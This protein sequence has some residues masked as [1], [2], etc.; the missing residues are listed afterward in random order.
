MK[1]QIKLKTLK[2]IY[3]AYSYELF[4][5]NNSETIVKMFTWFIDIVGGLQGLGKTYKEFKK[6]MK[7]LRSFPKK[8]EA[9]VT[10]IQEAKNL[11]K[12]PLEELI[13]SLMTHELTMKIHQ[14]V[15]DKKKKSIAL[16]VSTIE[17]EVEED[18]D[19]EWKRWRSSPYHKKIQEI[20]DGWKIQGKEIHF[21]KGIS[22]EGSFIK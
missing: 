18:N 20:Y 4:S 22:K 14:D 17:E 9:K 6:V 7:I 19:N 13:G 8:W 1:E 16:K 15:E 2:L 11:T 5:I 12:L 3:F 10:T 21:K